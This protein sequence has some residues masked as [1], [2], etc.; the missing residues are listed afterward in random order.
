MAKRGKA[1]T[2]GRARKG[3]QDDEVGDGSLFEIVRGG[4]A[5]LQVSSL[6]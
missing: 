5:S 2:A 1:N 3:A 4:R 6:V